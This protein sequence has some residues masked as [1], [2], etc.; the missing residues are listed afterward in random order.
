MDSVKS[1]DTNHVQKSFALLY[2]NNEAEEREF[3]E[4]IPLI[5]TPKTIKYLGINLTKDVKNLYCENYR[6]L[7]KRN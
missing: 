7:M 4:S 5:I 3:K 2:T 1:Q 6:T